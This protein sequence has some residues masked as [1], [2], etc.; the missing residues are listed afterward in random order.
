MS[1]ASEA[2]LDEL[3]AKV[4]EVL[5]EGLKTITIPVFDKDG[6]KTGEREVQ[7]SPQMLAQAIKFLAVNGINAPAT[8]KRLTNLQSALD[9]LDREFANGEVSALPN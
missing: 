6:K 9:E 2:A 8:S 5:V 7:P 4:A 1:R 3:H